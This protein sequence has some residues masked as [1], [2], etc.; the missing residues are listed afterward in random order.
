MDWFDEEED[1]A[2]KAVVKWIGIISVVSVIA[3]LVVK[4]L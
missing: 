2:A 3:A 4:Y 1:R